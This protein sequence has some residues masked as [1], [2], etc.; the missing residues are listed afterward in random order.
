MTEMAF[1]RVQRRGL[2]LRVLNMRVLPPRVSLFMF[3]C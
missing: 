2:Q 1:Y 3:V